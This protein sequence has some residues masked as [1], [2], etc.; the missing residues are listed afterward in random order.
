MT[1]PATNWDPAGSIRVVTPT[2]LGITTSNPFASLLEDSSSESSFFESKSIGTI[3]STMGETNLKELAP[4]LG[5]EIMQPI[6][7]DMN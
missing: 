7:K 4:E 5:Q 6:L 2:S 1:T 3:D